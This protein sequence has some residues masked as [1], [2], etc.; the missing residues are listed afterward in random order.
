ME[1]DIEKL[2]EVASEELT[3][4]ERGRNCNRDTELK[5]RQKKRKLQ[6]EKRKKHKNSQ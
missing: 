4:E 2:L 6:K 3:N 5:Q 1:D